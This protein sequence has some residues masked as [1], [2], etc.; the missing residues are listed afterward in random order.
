[1]TN[2]VIRRR[3]GVS[4]DAVKYHLRNA[5]GK[6][7]LHTRADLQYWR[8]APFD[9]ALHA[10]GAHDVAE[11]AGAGLGPIGQV[12]RQVSDLAASVVWYRDVLG[13]THLATFGSL[14]FFDCHGIRLFLSAG[15]KEVGEP[16]DSVLYFRSQDIEADYQR[17]TARGVRFRGAPHM[18]HRHDSG[19]EEWMAFF[20]DPDGKL[21]ALMSQ[22]STGG[23]DR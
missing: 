23:T 11:H 22:V 2:G 3:L 6:L 5:R 9:S 4:L 17:L 20:E 16:G 15:S 7:S 8:G 10:G 18:V 1:M 19:A 14:A 13:L 21:L 12:S